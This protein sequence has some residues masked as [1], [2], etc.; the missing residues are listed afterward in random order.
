MAPQDMSRRDL[1]L[2]TGQAA[3]LG[4]VAATG[5][6]P[7]L[8]EP[9]G[10]EEV[11]GGAPDVAGGKRARLSEGTNIAIS[12]SPDGK[13]LAMD[14]VTAIWVLPAGGG[15]A[16]RLTDESQDA[17]LP[18]WSP[19]G[20]EIVFQSYRDGNF[21][22]YA[23][24]VAGGAP[25]QL[26]RGRFDH[27]EPVFAP[28]GKRIALTS[29]R[30]GHYG[31]WLLDIASGDLTALTG[32]PDEVAAPRWSADG[33]RLVFAVDETAVDV[34]TVATGERR[35]VVTAPSGARLYGAAFGPGDVPSY[36][37]VRGGRA[38]LVLG[39]R[40]VTSGE[41]VFGFAATWVGGS[42]LYAADGR[43]RWRE[44]GGAVRD[45]PFEAVV[46]VSAPMPPRRAS[47]PSGGPVRG[48]ASP[49]VSPD[50][51]R[52]AFRALNAV[53]VVPIG[54]GRPRR[55]TDGDWFDSDPDFAPDGRSLVY[56]S[57]RTGVPTLRLRDLGT[58]ADRVLAASGG[59]QTA[60]RFAPDGRRVAYV[61]Q[62]GVVW[63]SDV[64]TGERR[65]VTPPLFMPG[66][67]TWSPDG[68]VLALA[69]VKPYSR[70]F[71]EG[72][73]QVLTVD[74]A[75]G[76]LRYAE[77]MPFRS[78]AT[79][80]DDGPVWSPDGRHLA[81]VV[82][83]VAWVVPVDAAGRFLGEPRQVTDEVTDSLAWHGSDALVHLCNGVLRRVGL[84]GGKRTI[85]LDFQWRR[86]KEPER[87]VVRVDAVWDGESDRLRRDVDIVVEGGRVRE[88]R[89]QRGGG[90]VVDA[91]GLVAMPGLVD[92]HNHWHLRGRQW[93]S[94]Q[95][96][97]WL[98]YGITTTR[99]PGDPVYQFVETREALAA[100]ALVGPRLFGTGEAVD[101][102]RVYYNF[103]RPTLSRRQLRLELERAVE[104]D[105]D[106]VKTYVRLPVESQR[107][108]VAAAHRAGLRLTSHYLYP[109]ANL[110][111]DGMEHV[112]ATNRLGYSHTV[113]RTGRA[114]QDVVELFG[115][116]GMS[117]TPTLFQSRALYA[118]DKSLVDDERTR[119]LFP[120]WEYRR[121]VAEAN[122]AGRPDAPFSRAV[123]AGWVD[124]VLRVH[125]AGGLVICGT[126]APLD[127]VA[128][129][130]HQNLRAMVE[131][132]FTPFEALTTATRNPAA[133]LGMA[134]RIGTLRPGA[135]ADI[136]FVAG[137]PLS[138]IRAAAAVR[139]VMVG[140]VLHRVEDLL[141]PFRSPAGGESPAAAEWRAGSASGVAAGEHW[142][143]EPEWAVHACCGEF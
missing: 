22:L 48:I 81:F 137:D 51:E 45:V 123:L 72:T 143:H 107:S 105:Y 138:D 89:P 69:A 84:A 133:W 57:D 17:T 126:D 98:A 54:G 3:A 93:G 41:D 115:R 127:W 58:G 85:R 88:I 67:P 66:R 55:L 124:M 40:P 79:R 36:T 86:P 83:S 47:E 76:E 31:L 111:V 46:P 59:A 42:A 90:R 116:T 96:R 77:P 38:D 109:A 18:T 122:D 135:H 64:A 65:Q 20:R 110:G 11:G 30:G 75:G 142:W 71:R 56:S 32:P 39:D 140:G 8:A 4:A 132:G 53:Y 78:I 60:P 28:D 141:A 99:S 95:G 24:D 120:P 7:A 74:L 131:Y 6:A 49:V 70:R 27:R 25:R 13:W 23:V 94:R 80:G 5:T 121:Y 16:R 125:R 14:L 87:V 114:Y 136:A 117:V 82:E 19:D 118:D 43:I 134:G 1:L 139:Q 21:H 52:I 113:S 92:A 2:R 35:R 108:A 97:V 33:T 130:T 34:L 62:D 44:P 112:G 63:V 104:L 10:T 61:D 119:V 50:G 37:L 128:T 101:G 102:S 12:A 100:G 73:S 68:R 129:A 26:T 91:R 9:G 106:L 29:D 103:M 15:T